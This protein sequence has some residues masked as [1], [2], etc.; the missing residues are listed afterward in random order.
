MRASGMFPEH[1]PFII[2][3]AALRSADLRFG[4]GRVARPI[5]HFSCAAGLGMKWIG[6]GFA[7]SEAS[8]TRRSAL[9]SP[10]L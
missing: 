2:L 4:L 9:N 10:W 8:G 6:R 3:R 5:G 7:P 1:C